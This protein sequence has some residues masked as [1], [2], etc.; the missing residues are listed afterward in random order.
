VNR[1]FP[2][3]LILLAHYVHGE[4]TPPPKDEKIPVQP[5][6]VT[7]SVNPIPTSIVAATAIPAKPPAEGRRWTGSAALV[8]GWDDNVLLQ[9]ANRPS[10][11]DE[12]SA[13]LGAELRL[14]WHPITTS[15]KRLD[16]SADGDQTSY[17]SAHQADLSRAGL[18]AYGQLT[19]ESETMGRLDP[20]LLIA[21]H[22]YWLDGEGAASSFM[23]TAMVT[24][25]KPSWVGVATAGLVQLEYDN[26]SSASGSMLEANYRHL[27]LLRESD[28]RRN[29]ELSL[30][31][32]G[33]FADSDADTYRTVTGALAGSWRF[34]QR[35][36][37]SGTIDVTLRLSL[38]L[39]TYDQPANA[40]QAENQS[41]LRVGGQAAWWLCSKASLGPYAVISNRDSNVDVSDYQRFQF[42]LRFETTF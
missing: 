22:R 26:N 32:G 12:S 40:G 17:P 11:T 33:Y 20:G 1:L 29:F 5:L 31:G 30:R 2:F 41:I 9:P 15:T 16:I 21:A 7:P 6:G 28:P 13:V 25:V 37:E 34:G 10:A 36:I 23:A 8:G 18:R 27:F 3:A 19:L 4:D 38:E 42:G 24:K 39:R 35:Q 14:A